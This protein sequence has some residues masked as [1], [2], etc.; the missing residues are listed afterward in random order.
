MIWTV[1]TMLL[2]FVA[3]Q[4]LIRAIPRMATAWALRGLE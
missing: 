2:A 4:G 3:Y 1:S